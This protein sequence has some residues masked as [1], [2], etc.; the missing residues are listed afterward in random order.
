MPLGTNRSWAEQPIGLKAT[1]ANVLAALTRINDLPEWA[2]VIIYYSGHGVTDPTAKD[3]WLQLAGQ[4]IVSH[5][6]GISAC[7]V[8][9]TAR[10]ASYLGELHVII[11]ACFSG[12]GALTGGL[13]LK[14]FGKNTTILTSSEE[15]QNSYPIKVDSRPTMS[16]FTHTLLRA[17]GAEC[18][19]ADDTGDGHPAIFRTCDL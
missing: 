3:V 6:E 1:K 5:H 17:L 4:T 13:T 15:I 12:R 18:Q 14:E 10:G 11:D 9:E 7:G 16:A 8:I 19:N 2:T